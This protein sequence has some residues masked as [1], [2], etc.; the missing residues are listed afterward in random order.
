MGPCRGYK[1][2]FEKNDIKCH[3]IITGKVRRSHIFLEPYRYTSY[4]GWSG[5]IVFFGFIT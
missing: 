5:S 1:D 2:V 3:N 4:F